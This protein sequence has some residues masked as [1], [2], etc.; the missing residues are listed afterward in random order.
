MLIEGGADPTKRNAEGKLPI[1]SAD[2]EE[3]TELVEFLK[4]YTPDYTPIEREPD[5]SASLAHVLGVSEIEHENG[6]STLSLDLNRLQE[7]MQNGQLEELM[8]MQEG[9]D[10]LEHPEE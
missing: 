7:L 9:M 6:E 4:T 3:R 5:E 2:E 8:R 1:E 10:G